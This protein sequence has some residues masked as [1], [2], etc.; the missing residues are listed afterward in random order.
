MS[1]WTYIV[2]S[3]HINTYIESTTIK[4]DI[5]KI[6]EK[7][8]KITGSERDA[9]IFV[10]ILSGHNIWN[11]GDCKICQYKDTVEY[12][13]DGRYKCAAE[14]GFKCPESEY[15]TCAVITIVGDLRDRFTDQTKAEWKSFVKFIKDENEA[16]FGINNC[17]CNIIGTS[18]EEY[19]KMLKKYKKEQLKRQNKNK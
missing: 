14:E 15:Q 11:S 6:L 10:N 8:P 12:L 5:E 19:E 7:A 3:I 18:Q 16:N 13:G 9:D 1:F 4:E 17:S 2:G